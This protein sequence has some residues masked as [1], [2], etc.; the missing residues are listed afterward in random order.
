MKKIYKVG[1]NFI[2]IAKVYQ[3]SEPSVKGMTAFY[4]G[5]LVGEINFNTFILKEVIGGIDRHDTNY[6]IEQ[7]LNSEQNNPTKEYLEMFKAFKGEQ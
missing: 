4:Y 6:F 2:D 5:S 7:E 3:M 1:N